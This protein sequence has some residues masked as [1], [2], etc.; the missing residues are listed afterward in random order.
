ME[1]IGPSNRPAQ[2]K[3]GAS[4]PA[5]LETTFTTSLVRDSSTWLCLTFGCEIFVHGIEITT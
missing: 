4:G 2:E 3:S 1:G 5:F